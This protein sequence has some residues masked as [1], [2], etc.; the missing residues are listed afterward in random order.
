MRLND[1]L[2]AREL[3]PH[4][5]ISDS[6]WPTIVRIFQ[7]LMPRGQPDSVRLTEWEAGTL[8]EMGPYRKLTYEVRR[9]D[10]SSRVQV[11]LVDD[12]GKTFVSTLRIVH[13]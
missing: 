4:A 8:R 12:S 7:P 11:W 1:S 6:G 13:P 9:V 2:G 3:Q 10:S 5:V